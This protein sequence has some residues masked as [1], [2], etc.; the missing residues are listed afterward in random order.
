MSQSRP[1]SLYVDSSYRQSL[2]QVLPFFDAGPFATDTTELIFRRHRKSL[3]HFRG[4]CEDRGICHRSFRRMGDMP[5][6]AGS[7]V[8]YPF[9]AQS[10]CRMCTN[11]RVRHV[12]VGHGESEKAASHKPILRIYDHVIV[13]GA[14][15]CRRLVQSG[16]FTQ[17]DV[18][19]GRII[20]LGDT[21][22][23]GVDLLRPDPHGAVLYAP[24]W[25]G[26][27][28]AE[29]YSSIQDGLGF[30]IAAETAA[31]L[32]TRRI[33]IKF[34][35]NTGARRYDY[36][37]ECYRGLVR[38]RSAGFDVQVVDRDLNPRLAIF[39]RLFARSSLERPGSVGVRLAL[40]DLSGLAAVCLKQEIP[41]LVLRAADRMGACIPPCLE[42]IYQIKSIRFGERLQ[43]TA[44]VLRR[45][46]CA[47]GVERAHKD[48]TFEY[49][50][51][52]LRS[53]S[54]AARLEW[55]AEHVK[56]SEYWTQHA[57]ASAASSPNA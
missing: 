40:V 57:R 46:F 30:R 28:D 10:N 24:T 52:E 23:Q 19:R 29:N 1:F 42:E 55:L 20:R 12:F 35:P 31:E 3:A 8:L 5:K 6:P 13:A 21:F 49:Q 44:A 51:P 17:Y 26:G 32:G 16:I 53:M 33:V 7:L 25:E 4:A 48:L 45:Y 41:H 43:S 56:H 54:P 37:R 18:D 50:R 11:R 14:L 38:L 47:D 9:N 34:H 22:V 39:L 2:E 15:A 36:L 27:L